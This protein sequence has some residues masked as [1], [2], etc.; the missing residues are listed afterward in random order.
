MGMGPF[1]TPVHVSVVEAALTR[2]LDVRSGGALERRFF[3]IG[4]Q[5]LWLISRRL[6]IFAAAGGRIVG[7]VRLVGYFNHRS[8]SPMLVI[9]PGRARMAFWMGD[10]CRRLSLSCV[11]FVLET[12][13]DGNA[14]HRRSAVTGEFRARSGRRNTERVSLLSLDHGVQSLFRG[15]SAIC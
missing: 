7:L 10:F 8:R 14:N 5:V 1:F 11:G 15:L 12:M 9:S 4:A 13:P 6:F 2:K 3:N